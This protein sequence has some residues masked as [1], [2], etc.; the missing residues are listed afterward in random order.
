LRLL[1]QSLMSGVARALHWASRPGAGRPDDPPRGRPVLV[2]RQ[3][4][5]VGVWGLSAPMVSPPNNPDLSGPTRKFPEK[6][7]SRTGAS[8]KRL[9]MFSNFPE[10]AHGR[11][12]TF[13]KRFTKVTG[14]SKK[15]SVGL[16]NF[17]KRVY[18]SYR[19]FRKK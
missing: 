10:K 19:T 1:P 4:S 6:S 12:R 8:R 14:L 17:L 11:Y 18:Q 13:L 15:S 3:S 7:A 9:P 16:S 5:F 2:R